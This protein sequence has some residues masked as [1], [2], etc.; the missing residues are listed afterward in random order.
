MSARLGWALAALAAA[1]GWHQAGGLGLLA[2]FSAVVFWL[3]LLWSRSLR[4]LRM[5]ASQPKGQV[6]DAAR[7]AAGL[8]PG[9]PAVELY[10][11]ARALGEP[12]PAWPDEP[13]P[14]AP[15]EAGDGVMRWQD[16]MGRRLWAEVRQG[17]LA[18]WRLDP[19]A[20]G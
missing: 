16:P 7:L 2:V 6:V 10:G 4:V 8:R 15:P 5:V 18:R 3:L 11:R 17:R 14:P 13:A 20:P 12:Q 19:P 9:L 1:L